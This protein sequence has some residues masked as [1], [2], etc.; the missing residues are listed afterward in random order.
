[1]TKKQDVTWMASI[2]EIGILTSLDIQ[3]KEAVA[4]KMIK[5]INSY[6]YCPYF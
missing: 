3:P 6:K 2:P 5:F 4:G 1:V